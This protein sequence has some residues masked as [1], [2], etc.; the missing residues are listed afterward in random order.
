VFIGCGR[1]D[2]VNKTSHFLFEFEPM[3]SSC[4]PNYYFKEE[5]EKPIKKCIK[6]CEELTNAKRKFNALQK[7]AVPRVK[8]VMDDSLLFEELNI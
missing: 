8:L 4:D 2:V 1:K 6:N 7:A 5:E 3:D